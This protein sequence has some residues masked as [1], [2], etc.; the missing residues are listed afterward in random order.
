MRVMGSAYSPFV[1][2]VRVLA[3]ELG[4][5]SRIEFVPVDTYDP[6]NG[7]EAYNPLR[8]VPALVRDDGPPLYDSAVICDWLCQTYPEP[9]M[10][11]GGERRWAVL[12][13]QALA[14]GTIDAGGAARLEYLRSPG[15]RS[16]AFYD[17]QIA[18]VW[19][20]IET[21]DRE[22]SWRA[23]DLD[24]GQIAVAC[25][26]GWLTFRFPEED[27]RSRFPELARW[28]TAFAARPSMQA[29]APRG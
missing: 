17:K 26:L 1:R 24:L 8:K 2:K 4:L 25:A 7:L 22:T 20:A 28:E 6:A 13:T 19:R 23:A 10:V 21:F 9:V 15:E 3:I 14:D 18:T 16:K 29:T 12:V 11:P 27:W 5:E